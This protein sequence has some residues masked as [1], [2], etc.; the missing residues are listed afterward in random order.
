MIIRK[1]YTAVTIGLL[2]FLSKSVCAQQYQVLQKEMAEQ[3]QAAELVSVTIE[4]SVVQN[5]YALTK[6]WSCAATRLERIAFNSL[7][8]EDLC[9]VGGNYLIARR[10]GTNT[11]SVYDLRTGDL[12]NSFENGIFTAAAISPD[13]AWIVFC[14]TISG[15]VIVNDSATGA[16]IKRFVIAMADYEQTECSL[17]FSFDK[18]FLY[19]LAPEQTSAS[20]KTYYGKKCAFETGEVTAL[21]PGPLPADIHNPEYT[22]VNDLH[23]FKVVWKEGEQQYSCW[24]PYKYKDDVAFFGTV[25]GLNADHDL[26]LQIHCV[27]YVVKC[28]EATTQALQRLTPVQQRMLTK[29]EKCSKRNEGHLILSPAEHAWLQEQLPDVV[30][31]NIKKNCMI[32]EANSCCEQIRLSYKYNRELR[33]SMKCG[34]TLITI[35]ILFGALAIYEHFK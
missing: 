26:V 6:Q 17:Y 28:D 27:L 15:N 19:V 23:E 18:R 21:I 31:Q 8:S 4:M 25:R 34:T 11:I 30:Q 5:K 10:L 20:Q 24:L 12:K 3:E 9:Q 29:F 7:S 13:G 33:E 32:H 16:E 1:Q 14:N 22:E 35:G 2:L